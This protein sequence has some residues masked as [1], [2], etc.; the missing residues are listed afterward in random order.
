MKTIAKPEMKCHMSL[1][2]EAKWPG[3]SRQ[4]VSTYD[5]KLIFFK[6]QNVVLAMRTIAKPKIICHM[7][8]LGEAEWQ[9]WSRQQVS[10]YDLKLI[11]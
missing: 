10:T 9:G 3:S 6:K 5:L 11:L 7:S 8:L 4:Q 1:L 2:C